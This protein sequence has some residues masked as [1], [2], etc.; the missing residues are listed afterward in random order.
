MSWLEIF[1]GF[2]GFF[3]MI[4]AGIGVYLQVRNKARISRLDYYD[5]GEYLAVCSSV[6]ADRE[7]LYISSVRVD[8]A[9][10]AYQAPDNRG[11]YAGAGQLHCVCSP[12]DSSFVDSIKLDW[13][14]DPH[15]SSGDLILVVKPERRDNV[16]IVFERTRWCLPMSRKIQI[17]Q[18]KQIV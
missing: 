14:L 5:H 17:K 13:Y 2:C 9:K 15:K 18:T 16:K 4:F 8:G 7:S 11:R 12:D 3:G 10:I 6:K 1:F